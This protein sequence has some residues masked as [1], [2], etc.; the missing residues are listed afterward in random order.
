MSV[1][2][3]TVITIERLLTIMYPLQFGHMRLKHARLVTAAGWFVCIVLS[4]VPTLRLPYF[5]D[6]FFG[7]TGIS[8]SPPCIHTR[9]HALA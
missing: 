7:S 5:G 9:M 8:G 4:V 1:F 3:L 6:A 2:M